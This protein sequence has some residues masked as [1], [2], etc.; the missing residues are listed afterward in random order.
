VKNDSYYRQHQPFGAGNGNVESEFID[1]ILIA[2]S[3]TY[4]MYQLNGAEFARM[5]SADSTTV[6]SLPVPASVRGTD[7]AVHAMPLSLTIF[8]V[9]PQA[10][11]R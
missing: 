11:L 5:I 2:S 3:F 4:F 6:L 1:I 8:S 9:H 7:V 10:I